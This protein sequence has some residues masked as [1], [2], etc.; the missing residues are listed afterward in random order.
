MYIAAAAWYGPAALW[1]AAGVVVAVAV[2]IATI[3]ATRRA[4]TRR[5]K[6]SCI[7]RYTPLLTDGNSYSNLLGVTYG[8]ITIKRPTI[9]N[10]WLYNTGQTDITSS[11][12]DANR[13]FIVDI[14]VDILA[15]IPATDGERLPGDRFRIE[16]SQVM[17][18]PYLI[19]AGTWIVSTL[20]VEGIPENVQVT[21]P[22]ISTDVTEQLANQAAP[23]GDPGVK[24]Y[25]SKM[26][27]QRR[28]Q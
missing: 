14:G 10:I 19:D 3:R 28:H 8:D 9:V 27:N 20:L 16:G 21:N 26:L 7:V 13:P 25:F 23:A 2:G 18:G 1:A 12:F 4:A 22:L 17:I 5:H 11:S 6:L 24:H 15:R